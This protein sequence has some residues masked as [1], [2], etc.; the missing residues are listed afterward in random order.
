MLP[1]RRWKLRISDIL[2][3]MAAI[4]S[5]LPPGVPLLPKLLEPKD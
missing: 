4:Q 3:A 2:D 1:E 5:D